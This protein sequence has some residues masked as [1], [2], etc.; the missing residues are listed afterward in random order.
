VLVLSDILVRY[1]AMNIYY[2]CIKI[3]FNYNLESLQ[4]LADEIVN[5]SMTLL[6]RVCRYKRGNQNP[7]IKEQT[8][9]WRKEKV[10]KEKQR[11]TKRIYKAKGRVKR[12]PHTD[13]GDIRC[14][15]R[16]CR[17]CSTSG[18][19]RVNLVTTPIISR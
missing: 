12:F 8:T 5:S 9:Q 1:F 18:T 6:I 15:R 7:H 19:R 2:C 13:C 4:I 3:S 11:S 17:S 10:Q 14:L 16:V